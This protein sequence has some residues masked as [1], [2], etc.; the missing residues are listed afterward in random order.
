MEGFTQLGSESLLSNDRTRQSFVA[1]RTADYTT[2]RAKNDFGKS[3]DQ[4]TGL[5]EIVACINLTESLIRQI[6]L[7][8]SH[9]C[10][11]VSGG[12]QSPSVRVFHK[13]LI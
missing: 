11:N 12:R 10:T 9:C 8:L 2:S 4:D 6:K 7:N 13:S 1:I 5:S 3:C